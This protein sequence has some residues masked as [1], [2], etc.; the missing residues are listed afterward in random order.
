M[1][2]V[3]IHIPFCKQACH[4]CN[5]HFSTSLRHRSSISSAIAAEFALTAD[6]LPT[7]K[8]KSIYFGGGTPSLMTA[9]DLHVIMGALGQHYQWDTDTEITLEANPDDITPSNLE[10]W[11]EQ[12][13]N[14]LSIGIQSFH[15][16]DL[17]AMNRAHTAEEA[18]TCIDLARE[19]GFEVF[20]I[21]LIYGAHTTSDEMWASTVD[22]AINLDLDHISAYCLTVEE[23]T[24][25][26]SFVNR[27]IV[28]PV[29][30]DRARRQF[31]YLIEQLA[32]RGYHHYEISNF[33][34]PGRYAMHNTSYWQGIPYLG[35]GPSAHSFDG[36]DRMY[37]VANNAKYLEAVNQGQLPRTTEHL[38][39]KE[40]YHDYILTSIR[41]MWGI[42]D[43]A[44]LEKHQDYYQHY[45]R[46]VE[47]LTGEGKIVRQNGYTILTES[48]KFI[49]DSITIDLMID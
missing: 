8:L 41:T 44:V 40:R 16:E 22:Q 11:L 25:L 49:A 6:Y 1:A 9:E 21:D 24:A 7:Q 27:Q 12:G 4:Y 13:I 23:G 17:L 5:F 38:T 37:N 33:A 32:L 31:Y 14:R 45:K 15:Q 26:A 47:L 18:H 3:Y 43:Q 30:D 35:V 36:T 34:K 29:D 19:A 20:T 39:P 2:G 46:Q 48:A 10:L 42:S 28:P